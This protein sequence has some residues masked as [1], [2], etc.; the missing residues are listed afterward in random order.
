M[1]KK[2]FTCTH[3]ECCQQHREKAKQLLG[4]LT[5]AARRSLFFVPKKLLAA[6]AAL[7][8]P[9]RPGRVGRWDAWRAREVNYN[10]CV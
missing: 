10:D 2:A 4:L 8:V 9:L 5:P 6:L 1:L 7:A 3:A